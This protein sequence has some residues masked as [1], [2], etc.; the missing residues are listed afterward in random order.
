[1]VGKTI[2]SFWGQKAHFQGLLLLVLREGR[3]PEWYIYQIWTVA[4]ISFQ[5]NRMLDYR[6]VRKPTLFYTSISSKAPRNSWRRPKACAGLTGF[7]QIAQKL[8]RQE[9]GGKGRG[10]FLGFPRNG[11]VKWWRLENPTYLTWN[12]LNIQVWFKWFSFWRS[13]MII[14]YKYGKAHLTWNLNWIL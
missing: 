1:M 4:K 10:G 8:H 11:G 6:S 9:L 12:F 14:D 13:Y 2:P 5:K 3:W 7:L